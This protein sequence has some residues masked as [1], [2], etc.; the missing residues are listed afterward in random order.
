MKLPTE[1]ARWFV[2]V[3]WVAC[4][5]VF[6]AVSLAW[7]LGVI[8]TPW[9]LFW[10]GVGMVACNSAFGLY[11]RY[12]SSTRHHAHAHPEQGPG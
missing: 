2:Q 9:P 11:Q 4:A 7:T 12:W 8:E 10:V 6:G 5:I 3:R 1:G